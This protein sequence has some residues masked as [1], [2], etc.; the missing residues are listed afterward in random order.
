[1]NHRF[2]CEGEWKSAGTLEEGDILTLAD[3]SEAIVTK[4]TFEET[5]T[6]VY[7]MEVAD[8]HTYY[9]G[10]D[11]VWVHNNN[12]ACGV[13]AGTGTVIE[14]VACGDCLLAVE[15]TLI[16]CGFLAIF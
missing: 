5:H 1:M 6:T 16:L 12:G 4:V 11:S 14:D 2:W 9:V 15:E 7:N 8:Y 10:E 3:G 13:T